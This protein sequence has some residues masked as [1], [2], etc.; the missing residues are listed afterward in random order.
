MQL[1]QRAVLEHTK[2][3]KVHRQHYPA[4]F[5]R[6]IEKEGKVIRYYSDTPAMLYG[7]YVLS[8]L[9]N[10]EHSFSHSDDTQNAPLSER[11]VY[12]EK[13][14]EHYWYIAAYQ[15][16]ELD[17]EAVGNLTHLLTQFGYAIHHAKR[18]WV[19]HE[20]FYQ[21][22]D[23]EP[24]CQ[25]LDNS[26]WD[27]DAQAQYALEAVKAKTVPVKWVV[28][29]LAVTLVIAGVATYYQATKPKPVK[30]SKAEIASTKYLNTYQTRMVDARVALINARNLLIEASV[31][32]KGMTAD[33]VVLDRQKLVMR[34]DNKD[35][36]TS[37][38]HQWFET[39]PTLAAF[40][41]KPDFVLPL[42]AP[43]AWQALR[44]IGY[45][46][47]LTESVERLGG[48]IDVEKINPIN[49]IPITTYRIKTTGNLG[50][51]GVLADVLNA[52]FIALNKLQMSRHDQT[53]TLDVTID[54]QGEPLS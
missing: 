5:E 27:T 1:A 28:V 34:V 46:R 32:P 24:R 22:Y 8:Q 20:D 36:K 37:T 52:P 3:L 23:K 16:G 11:F 45:H 47:L 9:N 14:D 4:E 13:R 33:K 35:V 31:M 43:T 51:I 26:L 49:G 48:V 12:V 29:F 2:A 25:T 15:N 53:L 30:R 41:D 39:H 10:N 42:P 17:Q 50:H 54:V 44:P 7:D 21:S 19:T 6:I 18:L 40:Y 38:V